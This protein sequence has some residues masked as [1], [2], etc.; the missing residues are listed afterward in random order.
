MKVRAHTISSRG[1]RETADPRVLSAR[2]PSR[3]PAGES[4]L[5]QPAWTASG[6]LRRLCLRR[7]GRRPRTCHRAASGYG[8]SQGLL[9]LASAG[10]YL[11]AHMLGPERW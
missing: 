6:G 11:R 7:Q 8:L 3:R 10:K 1:E 2:C 4:R 5:L 9:T